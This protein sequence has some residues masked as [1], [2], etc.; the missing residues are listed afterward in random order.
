MPIMPL[1]HGK[2]AEEREQDKYLDLIDKHTKA[3]EIGFP[4][5]ADYI[6]E[7]EE[8]GL[9][10]SPPTEEILDAFLEAH[11]EYVDISVDDFKQMDYVTTWGSD[12]EI[13]AAREQQRAELRF[14]HG[15]AIRDKLVEKYPENKDYQRAEYVNPETLELVYK[16]YRESDLISIMRTMPKYNTPTAQGISDAQFADRYIHGDPSVNKLLIKS[17]EPTHGEIFS[18]AMLEFGGN[19]IVDIPTYVAGGFD[20]VIKGL[21]YVG[22]ASHSTSK[23]LGLVDTTYPW[24]SFN[25]DYEHGMNT[26][27]RWL[28]AP[29]RWAARVQAFGVDEDEYKMKYDPDYRALMDWTQNT[30]AWGNLDDAKVWNRILSNGV[31][32]LLVNFA[33]GGTAFKTAKALG[34]GNAKAMS[35]AV[36]ASS[37]TSNLLEGSSELS[38]AMAYLMSDR[39]ISVKDLKS[40]LNDWEKEYLDKYYIVDEGTQKPSFPNLQSEVDAVEK[41][42]RTK[43]AFKEEMTA[44]FDDIYAKDEMGQFVKKGL[45]PIDAY[46]VAMPS[47]ITYGFAA[48]VLERFQAR[49]FFKLMPGNYGGRVFRNQMQGRIASKLE[50]KF[51]RFGVGTNKIFRIPDNDYLKIITA[52]GTESLQETGQ[53]MAQSIINSGLPGIAYKPEFDLD[54]NEVFESAVGGF[55]LGGGVQT[56]RTAWNKSGA[57]AYYANRS[58]SA[59]VPEYG[60]EYYVKKDDDGTWGLFM[61]DKRN[62]ESQLKVGDGIYEGKKD[63]WTSFRAANKV[64]QKLR[65]DERKLENLTLLRYNADYVDADIKNHGYNKKEKKYEVGIYHREGHLI[66]VEQFDTALEAKGNIRQYKAKVTRVNQS[67]KDLGYSNEQVLDIEK[68]PADDSVVFEGNESQQTAQT[69]VDTVLL[70]SLLEEEMNDSESKVEEEL[71]KK[72]AWDG[73]VGAKNIIAALKDK[74]ALR[75]V[76]L[77]EEDIA[78]KVLYGNVPFFDFIE[79]SYGPDTRSEAENILQEGPDAGPTVTPPPPSA[80]S[81]PKRTKAELQKRKAEIKSSMPYMEGDKLAEATKELETIDRE[82]E[83]LRTGKPIPS[84]QPDV[85]PTPEEAPEGPDAGPPPTD[86]KEIGKRTLEELKKDL[87]EAKKNESALGKILVKRLEKEIEKRKGKLKSKREDIDVKKT[88]KNI[89]KKREK[90]ALKE[91][92]KE[93]RDIQ[94]KQLMENILQGKKGQAIMANVEG[95]DEK[96]LEDVVDWVESQR[97]LMGDQWTDAAIA[98]VFELSKAFDFQQKNIDSLPNYKQDILK[99]LSNKTTITIKQIQKEFGLT[100]EGAESIFNRLKE[101]GYIGGRKIGQ[102]LEVF[103]D[104]VRK[105]IDETDERLQRT[106]KYE[107]NTESRKRAVRRDTELIGDK[108]KKIVKLE[109]GKELEYKIIDDKD[110]KF[111]GKWDWE[112]DTLIVNLAYADATTVVH[113]FMHPF[114][115]SLRFQN[116]AVFDKIYE[117]LKD[118]PE[119]RDVINIINTRWVGMDETNPMFKVEVV[120]E[121]I[122]KLARMRKERTANPFVNGVKKFLH[123]LKSLF[124]PKAAHISTYEIPPD[125]TV[126]QL[127]DMLENY[128]SP[129]VFEVLDSVQTNDYIASLASIQNEGSFE[130][131]IVNADR[132]GFQSSAEIIEHSYFNLMEELIEKSRDKNN[133]LNTNKLKKAFKNSGRKVIDSLYDKHRF[134]DSKRIIKDLDNSKGKVREQ[135]IQKLDRLNSKARLQLSPTDISEYLPNFSDKEIDEFTAIFRELNTVMEFKYKFATFLGNNPKTVVNIKD[136]AKE[137]FMDRAGLKKGEKGAVQS[138]QNYLKETFPKLVAMTGETMKQEYLNFVR[139]FYGM[140]FVQSKNYEDSLEY[141]NVY[142]PKK[143]G[144]AERNTSRIVFTNNFVF[145]KGHR[146]DLT[147]KDDV[148]VPGDFKNFNGLGW[149]AFD[150]KNND[151]INYEYQTDVLDWII[152]EVKDNGF[153]LSYEDAVK[154][155]EK[156]NKSV[157]SEKAIKAS[158]DAFTTLAMRDAINVA[159][160]QWMG[161]YSQKAFKGKTNFGIGSVKNMPKNFLEVEALMDE[162]KSAEEIIKTGKHIIDEK[163]V[164]NTLIANI[165][166]QSWGSPYLEKMKFEEAPIEMGYEGI[167]EKLEEYPEVADE[168]AEKVLGNWLKKETKYIRDN[169]NHS[170]EGRRKSIEHDKKYLEKAERGEIVPADD[171]PDLFEQV[172]PMNN[173]A[174]ESIETFIDFL[175]EQIAHEELGISKALQF[176]DVLENDTLGFYQVALHGFLTKL[177][178]NYL[179]ANDGAKAIKSGVEQVKEVWDDFKKGEL[180]DQMPYKGEMKDIVDNEGKIVNKDVFFAAD[181]INGIYGTP[182]LIP[183]LE[184]L[185]GN[186]FDVLLKTSLSVSMNKVK[187]DGSIYLGTAG[188]LA[189]VEGNDVAKEIYVSKAEALIGNFTKMMLEEPADIFDKDAPFKYEA[190]Q[191]LNDLNKVLPKFQLDKIEFKPA[192]SDQDIPGLVGTAPLK[193]MY[194]MTGHVH[195]H[196]IDEVYNAILPY[197]DKVNSW[198][199]G[200]EAAYKDKKAALLKAGKEWEVKYLKKGYISPMGGPWFSALEKLIKQKIIKVTL[201]RPSYSYWELYKVEILKP[202]ALIPERFQ[203]LVKKVKDEQFVPQTEGEVF[204][205]VENLGRYQSI[206]VSE[207][208]DFDLTR[209]EKAEAREIYNNAWK[210]ITRVLKSKNYTKVDPIYFRNQMMDYLPESL[211]ENFNEWYSVKFKNNEMVK[212]NRQFFKKNNGLIAEADFESEMTMLFN[213]SGYSEGLSNL[214]EE[215]SDERD[216][217]INERIWM[218]ELGINIREGRL[219]VLKKKAKL[220][221]NFDYFAEKILPIYAPGMN[222]TTLSRNYRKMQMTRRFFYR[223]NSYITTNTP[224]GEFNEFSNYDV[225]IT[226]D[227]RKDIPTVNLEVKLKDGENFRTGDQNPYAEK[228]TLFQHNSKGNKGLFNF[229]GG[230]DYHEVNIYFNG[231][232]VQ[233]L[234]GFLDA[235]Q[236]QAL[237]EEF[238]KIGEYG[239]AIAFMRGERKKLALVPIS[240]NHVADAK[241]INAY[242]EKERADGY[243]P[244]GGTHADH[245]VSAEDIAIHEATKAVWPMYLFDAKGASNVMKRLKIPFTPVTISKDMPDFKTKIFD[246]TKASFVFEDGKSVPAMINIPDVARKY[247]MDGG[248][249]ASNQMFKNLE[250]YGGAMKWSGSNKNVI[251]H[252]EGMK[253]IMFKHEMNIA[254]RNMEIWHD[255]GGPEER[256]IAK[257]DK[258]RNITDADGNNIDLL[259]TPDEVKVRDGYDLDIIHDLPGQSLGI[260]GYRDKAPKTS[261]HGTQWYSYVMDK[262]ILQSWY[263]NQLKGINTQTA[264]IWNYSVSKIKDGKILPENSA[265]KKIKDFL[266]ETLSNDEAGYSH[267]VLEHAKLGAG[268]HLG[269]EPQINQLIQ[270]KRM[271]KVTKSGYQPGTRVKLT[272]NPKGD[273]DPNEI[274]LAKQNATVVYQAYAKKEGISMDDARNKT[275]ISDINKWLAKNE[276]NMMITRYPVPHVGGVMVARIKRLHGRHGLV[277]MNPIDVYAKL[278]GDF[279]G[280]E[281]Q[282]EKLPAGQETLI[283]NYLDSLNIKGINLGKYVSEANSD[284][285]NFSETS[286]RDSIIQALAYGDR[287]IGEIANLMNVYGQL[288]KVFDSAVIDGHEIVLRGLDE[289]INW[290]QT[291]ERLPMREILRRYVQAALDNAEFLLLKEW[292][293]NLQHLYASLFK[294]ADGKPFGWVGDDHQGARV[295]EALKP[296]IEMHKIPGQIRR[297]SDFKRGRFK[298]NDVIEVSDMFTSYAINKQMFLWKQH[299]AYADMRRDG[300]GQITSM[301][302]IKFK[303]ESVIS[304]WE[305]VALAP[306]RTMAEHIAR[307]E[308]RGLGRTVFEINEYM[309][310]NAHLDATQYV[311]GRQ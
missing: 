123:W 15:V 278:E 13:E 56:T 260:I 112:N 200:K 41:E 188:F 161:I 88:V 186:W 11:Q 234:Y 250:E 1:K 256:L 4:D 199:Q 9:L 292:N 35:S 38:A 173:E 60:V 19:A 191:V 104:K 57:G 299:E 177:M 74:D 75:A 76:G 295:Y 30:S 31:P 197:K 268:L 129:P 227:N 237:K 193:V 167:L 92:I 245:I 300:V 22:Y 209:I 287:A 238:S 26:P 258:Y 58:I 236:Y 296:I 272:G 140:N 168:M 225:I 255:K 114:V 303:E 95:I 306:K 277:E 98:E 86:K 137:K 228:I 163:F 144:D 298:L 50:T 159:L 34:M 294:R 271:N 36:V 270:T 121:S 156:D 148:L 288:L 284:S 158:W 211:K 185:W 97:G 14:E 48:S 118:T 182:G 246:P 309:H 195:F 65:K 216:I 235:G 101:L 135:V 291:G 91:K 152:K 124:F 252:T 32:S 105:D 213:D 275:D 171:F 143:D 231:E 283:K 207:E 310:G 52:A 25:Q 125:I 203:S 64:A 219:K 198:V 269:M 71:S 18:N 264:A 132:D 289:V 111:R 166:M 12:A 293:Y 133:K 107:T 84:P 263:D 192:N 267:S 180:S 240:S 54:W 280:D 215:G 28:T 274:A 102:M 115:E 40:D 46:N 212:F 149:Y 281:V 202:E 51:G 21:D 189:S 184:S 134:L 262:D 61:S 218:N 69:R 165:L 151:I 169:L 131:D 217:G 232:R 181:T 147:I 24:Q 128:Y 210:D 242:I 311:T 308:R 99:F 230:K 120:V 257:V 220:A 106:V 127:A 113:E 214:V 17:P 8:K 285:L 297:G 239:T 265:A 302:D 29:G 162:G 87:K 93:I 208:G 67:V 282:L 164:R 307:H 205:K 126:R 109:G 138:F 194:E 221:P 233:D 273:L 153:Q 251:Y 44:Y 142:F 141:Q 85:T 62:G 170:I 70:K 82:L 179:I 94:V 154:I 266:I 254:P 157:I 145:K 224:K 247:I 116:K 139:E 20:M 5:A 261:T 160:N 77:T 276:V 223:I 53:T 155:W 27:T 226:R 55:T 3:A 259:A 206:E 39:P 243:I 279:D 176:I 72:N 183:S 117:Q 130:V 301:E 78:G 244:I 187:A 33:S 73:K 249:F 136:I 290:P 59:E 248:S 150:E 90:E 196:T 122:A 49:N 80:P 63:Q 10:V 7:S 204:D 37:T 119:G 229:V 2:K 253:T 89:A 96:V 305:E 42:I 108:L 241:N 16:Q 68:S 172:Y 190:T 110:Q 47:A 43:R 178:H 66:K 81:A 83:A 146:F 100:E 6:K 222:L 79:Q 45:S 103:G 174:F 304:P 175:K 201:G 286:S 23:A